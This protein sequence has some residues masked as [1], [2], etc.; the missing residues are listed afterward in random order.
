[1]HA[2]QC[3]R[4]GTLDEAIEFARI[5]LNSLKVEN[6][7]SYSRW[8]DFYSLC[9]AIF[10]K[11]NQQSLRLVALGHIR[12]LYEKMGRVE[13]RDEVDNLRIE[14]GLEEASPPVPHVEKPVDLS[15]FVLMQPPPL[16]SQKRATTRL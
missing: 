4:R 12:D 1:M 10:E 11:T 5:A 14:I 15:A 6:V 3:C 8:A 2:R 7:K 13:A 16:V 9:A